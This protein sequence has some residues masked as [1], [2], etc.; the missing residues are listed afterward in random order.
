MKIIINGTYGDFGVTEE[1]RARIVAKHDWDIDRTS[2]ELIWAVE[3]LSAEEVNGPYADLRVAEIPDN[4][5][6]WIIEEYD[7]FEKVMYVLDGKI[8]WTYGM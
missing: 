7:G 8:H 5:T 2:S 4:S 1:L 6:D 3:H